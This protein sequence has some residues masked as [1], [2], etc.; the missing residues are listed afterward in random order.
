MNNT[1]QSTDPVFAQVIV[2]LSEAAH[3]NMK[4]KY[5]SFLKKTN[6]RWG[7][8]VNIVRCIYFLEYH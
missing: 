4:Q 1:E 7:F 3:R 8:D 2:C 5:V 6:F